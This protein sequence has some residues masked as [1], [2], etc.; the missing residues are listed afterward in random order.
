M[1]RDNGQAMS[2]ENVEFAQSVFSRWNAGERR[3][4][5]E[6][7]HPDV[8]L[9]SRILGTAVHGR[10]GVRRYLLEID[11]QF[12]EWT[13]TI[14]DWRDEG[15]WVAALGRVRF[16]GRRSGVAFDQAVGILFEIREG[17]LVRFETFPGEPARALEAAGLLE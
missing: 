4:P 7:V 10:E 2:Q 9:L 5:D 15:D 8:V 16:H 11:E 17:Q 14:D 12:D 13:I 1:P 3:F 6:Q